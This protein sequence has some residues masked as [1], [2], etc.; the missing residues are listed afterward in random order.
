MSSVGGFC[1][2]VEVVHIDEVI[3][4]GVFSLEFVKEGT[5]LWTPSL[6]QKYSPEEAAAVCASKSKEEAN[7]WLRQA[8]I[9]AT[10]PEL[11]CVNVTD[12]GRFTNHSCKP[13]SGYASASMPSVALRDILPGEEITVDYSG[14]GSPQWYQDLCHL[15][16]VLPTDQVASMYP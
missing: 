9:L 7:I 16:G 14:L 10:E 13:N 12:N 15:Y 2:P 11:L 6:V 5:L 3:G 4:S 1:V 8:F